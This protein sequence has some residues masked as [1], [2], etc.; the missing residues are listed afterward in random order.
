[1]NFNKFLL[2]W[3][4]ETL[5]FLCLNERNISLDAICAVIYSCKDFAAKRHLAQAL[6]YF[7]IKSWS[8]IVVRWRYADLSMD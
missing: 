3:P 6:M 7:R 8:E 2:L 4:W 1:M 5:R